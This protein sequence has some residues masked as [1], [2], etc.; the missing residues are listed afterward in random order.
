MRLNE[1]NDINKWFNESDLIE[2][3]FKKGDFKFNFVKAGENS[4]GVKIS[5][6]LIS[7]NSPGV[8]IFNFSKK[9]KS[10]VI[11]EGSA[12]KKGDVLGYVR[13]L[14]KDVEVISPVSG[15]IKVISVDDGS[16][17]EYAQLLFIIE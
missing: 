9:G 15:K 13:V 1:I 5:S 4:G 6:N 14:N 17:V 2:L 7:V 3:G 10:V 16:V 12:V 11:K 8:G